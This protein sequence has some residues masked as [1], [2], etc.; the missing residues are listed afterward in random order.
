MRKDQIFVLLL[1]ILLPLTGC[2]GGENIGEVEGAQD[3]I[4]T[5]EEESSSTETEE[6]YSADTQERTWY[7]SG[8]VYQSYWNDG[9]Y[10]Y[11]NEEN[12]TQVYISSNSQRCLDYGPYYNSSNGDLIGERCNEF[13]Y[14]DSLSDW[15]LTSCTDAGGEIKWID[16]YDYE[17]NPWYYRNA[18]RCELHFATINVSAGQA[19]LIYEWSGFSMT[20]TCEN[21]ES[22]RSSASLSGREYFII[23]GSAMNCSHNIYTNIYYTA[24][25]ENFEKQSIWSVVYAIQDTTVI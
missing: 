20:S 3:T 17:Q 12:Q 5:T 23:P 7:S 21:V 18:P 10:S 1:V 19:L 24:S 11:Y 15:N 4:D 2:F 6:G 22:L 9:Q 14:P 16:T 13:G 25:E 8:G